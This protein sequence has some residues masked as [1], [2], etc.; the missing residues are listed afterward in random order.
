MSNHRRPILTIVNYG[1]LFSNDPDAE[2]VPIE[3]ATVFKKQNITFYKHILR[4]GSTDLIFAASCECGCLVGNFYTGVTCEDCETVV[5]TNFANDLQYRRWLVIPEFMPPIIQPTVFKVLDNWMGNCDKKKRLLWSFLNINLPFPDELAA[6]FKQGMTYFYE[7][8][9][10][11]CHYLLTEYKPLCVGGGGKRSKGIREFLDANRSAIFCRELPILNKSLH[12]LTGDNIKYTDESVPHILRAWMELAAT[13]DTYRNGI[14]SATYIDERAA[15]LMEDYYLY[16]KS[17]IVKK[18]ASKPGFARKNVFGTRLH[19]SSRAVITPITDEHQFDELYIP[20]RIGVASMK[21]EIINLLQQRM[22]Y[23]MSDAV[24]THA[25][26]LTSHVEEVYN[27]MLELIEESPYKGLPVYFGRNPSLQY[28]ALQQFFVTRIKTDLNDNTIEISPLCISGPNADFD[29]DA[30]YMIRLFEL[31][32]MGE[33][34]KLHPSGTMVSGTSMELSNTLRMCP[35]SIQNL[36][37]WAHD[38]V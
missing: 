22:F 10:D 21:L 26:A 19:F 36:N 20:W 29:G 1:E 28:G 6:R 27:V 5:A 38:D 4:E 12:L 9:D 13:A 31:D 30:M 16:T 15:E 23:S 18:I 33:Y 2:A 14:T 34:Q 37:L 24:R 3:E 25:R 32:L 11:I 7:N 17:I 8:F 35:E